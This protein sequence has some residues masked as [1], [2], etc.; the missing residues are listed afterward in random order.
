MKRNTKEEKF[1]LDFDEQTN[2]QNYK[3]FGET[4]NNLKHNAISSLGIC[5]V[6]LNHFREM[7]YEYGLNHT[8]ELITK[9]AT[10]LTK[11]FNLNELYRFDND[12]FSAFF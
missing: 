10:I 7:T 11:T 4:I 12:T 5:C 1:L 3:K 2:L 9:L 6:K 8:N